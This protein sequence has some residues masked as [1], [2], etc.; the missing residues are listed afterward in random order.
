MVEKK[1]GLSGIVKSFRV[2]CVS[3]GQHYHVYLVEYYTTFTNKYI[4]FC[5]NIYLV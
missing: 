5:S 4:Q 1:I 2:C 3:L